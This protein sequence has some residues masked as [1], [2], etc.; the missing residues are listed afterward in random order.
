[1]KI[2][3]NRLLTKITKIRIFSC[4]IDLMYIYI[5]TLL[6]QCIVCEYVYIVRGRESVPTKIIYTSLNRLKQGPKML[7]HD[8]PG[9]H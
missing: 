5:Y 1:M 3:T 9:K 4:S 2:N 7:Y 6:T 8:H